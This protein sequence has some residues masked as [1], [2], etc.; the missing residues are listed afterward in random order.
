MA[1][2]LDLTENPDNRTFSPGEL[3]GESVRGLGGA[4]T[5]NGAIDAEEINGNRGNDFV[6][7]G[8][9]NDTLLGGQDND[10]IN[11]NEGNDVL[12]GNNANDF[13]FGNTGDDIVRGGQ[14]DDQIFAGD[15]DDFLYGD[16]GTDSLTGGNGNDVFVLRTSTAVANPSFADVIFD[17]GNGADLIGLTGGTTEADISLV[18]GGGSLPFTN[19]DTLIRLGADFLGVVLNTAPG[20]I[21]GRF[22]T[23]PG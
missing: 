17:F 13:V 14:G 7:G 9:G 3:V 23:A 11:G 2:F 12:N 18:A 10:T 20:A 6:S 21:A 16:F 5:I 8:G 1:V 19:A 4:D 15:G 22:T